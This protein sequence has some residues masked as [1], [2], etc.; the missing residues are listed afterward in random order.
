MMP[1]KVFGVRARQ[2][3]KQKEAEERAADGARTS[4]RVAARLNLMRHA[5]CGGWHPSAHA[6]RQPPGAV[7]VN[8]AGR[9]VQGRGGK[10]QTDFVHAGAELIKLI[11]LGIAPTHVRHVPRHAAKWQSTMSSRPIQLTNRV[12]FALFAEILLGR[13]QFSPTFL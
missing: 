4:V 12:C 11:V 10:K 2:V 3:K 9:V 13:Q 5:S 1:H 8:A 7:A 6:G